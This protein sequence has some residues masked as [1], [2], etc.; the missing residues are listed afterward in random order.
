MREAVQQRDPTV[1]S[2]RI[3]NIGCIQDSFFSARVRIIHAGNIR[4]SVKAA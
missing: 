1:A 4:A 3:E 2:W